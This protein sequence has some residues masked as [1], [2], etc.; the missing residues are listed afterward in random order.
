M[1]GGGNLIEN[2]L[3]GSGYTQEMRQSR[4]GGPSRGIIR[5]TLESIPGEFGK[6]RRRILDPFLDD[7]CLHAIHPENLVFSTELI[8]S[9]APNRN[10]KTGVEMNY[11]HYSKDREIFQLSS[12]GSKIKRKVHSFQNGISLVIGINNIFYKKLMSA[13]K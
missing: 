2:S 3:L 7:C 4:D 1:G 5:S 11:S 6:S 9:R 13:I 8:M 10:C 12:S